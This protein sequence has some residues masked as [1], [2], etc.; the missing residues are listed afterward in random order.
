MD[1]RTIKSSYKLD[2]TRCYRVPLYLSSLFVSLFSP[3]SFLK[4]T[5]FPKESKVPV[6]FV[7]IS[8]LGEHHKEKLQNYGHSK[9]HNVELPHF[10]LTYYFTLAPELLEDKI[11]S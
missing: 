2:N 5:L 6:A 10:T 7:S 3:F 4:D 8:F 9:A 11:L 1:L